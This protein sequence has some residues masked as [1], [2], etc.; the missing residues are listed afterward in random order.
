MHK[1]EPSG[2]VLHGVYDIQTEHCTAKAGGAITAVWG[3]LAG[4]KSMSAGR[5]SKKRCAGASGSSRGQ[6]SGSLFEAHA[7][8]TT[9]KPNKGLE[10]TASSVRSAPAFGSSSGPALD[11]NGGQHYEDS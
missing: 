1:I 11:D 9:T 2:V 3:R 7:R 5:V 8:S 6:G 10:L 4:R